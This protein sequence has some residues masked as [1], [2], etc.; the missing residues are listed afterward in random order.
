MNCSGDRQKETK[1]S[2]K[3]ITGFN[4]AVCALHIVLFAK[5]VIY[6]KCVRHVKDNIMWFIGI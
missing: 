1:I 3:L 2:P 6:V 4:I 5:C